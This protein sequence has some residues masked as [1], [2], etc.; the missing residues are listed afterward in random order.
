M[1]RKYLRR[2]LPPISDVQNH[3]LLGRLGKRLHHQRL[4]HLNRRSV[5]GA[6][7]V[8]LFVAFLPVPFQ[9]VLA[10]LGALWLRVNLPL[11]VVLIF[12]T[13]PL[14]MGP[15]YYVCYRVGVWTTGA[16]DIAVGEDFTPTVEWLLD[17]LELIWQPLMVGSIIISSLAGLLGYTLVQ[18]AWRSH[19]IY[20]RKALL[21]QLARSSSKQKTSQ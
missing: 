8:G 21:K 6:T 1:P 20:K 17:Q 2:Y 7:G 4:W 19:T 13:N 16:T 18:L 12:I 10:G 9:F 14:T 5:S 11:A 15:A 3:W